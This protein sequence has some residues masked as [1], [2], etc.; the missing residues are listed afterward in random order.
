MDNVI[1]HAKLFSPQAPPENLP[2]P[3][4][5]EH[6]R[7]AYLL[8][9]LVAPAGYGKTRLVAQWEQENQDNIAIRWLK[10]DKADNDP[11]QFLRYFIAA[12]CFADENLS[13]HIDNASGLAH[14]S[15]ALVQYADRPIVIV[16][17]NYHLI[18][19]DDTHA[20]LDFFLKN[21][22]PQLRFIVLSRTKLPFTLADHR[23]QQ[24]LTEIIAQQLS[25]TQDEIASYFETYYSLDL[26]AQQLEIITVKTCGWIACI[27]ILGARLRVAEDIDSILND[28]S[29]R[30]RYLADYFSGQFLDHY[31]SAL[32]SFLIKSS[33]LNPLTSDSC[34]TVLQQKGSQEQFIELE[35][36]GAPIIPLDT[37]QSCY[38]YHP[39]FSEFLNQQLE[40]D[41]DLLVV[42]HER[43]SD[44]YAAQAD[45]SD[46][47]IE[48][49]LFHAGYV[50]QEKILMLLTQFSATILQQGYSHFF[51]TNLKSVP[52][53]ALF[54]YPRLLI[55]YLWALY[56]DGQF[57]KTLA[58]LEQAESILPDSFMGEIYVLR[59]QLSAIENNP[60]KS[61]QLAQQALSML[62]PEDIVFRGLMQFSLARLAFF[63]EGQTNQAITLLTEAISLYEQANHYAVWAI[64]VDCLIAIRQRQGS[65]LEA[66]ALC[67]YSI[68]TCEAINRP[69]FL[70]TFYSQLGKIL[71]ERNFTQ[72]AEKILRYGR[73]LSQKYKGKNSFLAASLTLCRII[74]PQEADTIR[75]ETRA[76]VETDAFQ[77][78]RIAA[79]PN[80]HLAEH[81]WIAPW[82]DWNTHDYN[83]KQDSVSMRSVYTYLDLARRLC[84]GHDPNP[85]KAI[86]L[87]LDLEQFTSKI[88]QRSSLL[89]VL[90]LLALSYK[91]IGDK[92]S[93]NGSLQRA[94]LIAQ[95]TGH[96]RLFLDLGKPMLDLLE[97]IIRT[98]QYT[99]Y[100]LELL[101]NQENPS[102]YPIRAE[103]SK[104]L[105][106]REIDILRLLTDGYSN[107]EIGR[108]FELS[109][110][111][112]R[113]HVKNIYRKLEVNNR[114]RATVRA[115]DLGLI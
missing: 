49:A 100:A 107:P 93:A 102:T 37:S 69:D 57:Y 76:F 74:S 52:Y 115:R 50:H 79:F 95:H 63:Y 35:N 109:V 20:I 2:R 45:V 16:L 108:Y 9:S 87:L 10:L 81:G 89:E 53:E 103:L 24:Q 12:L 58:L 29:G 94:L 82:I 65:L 43:A 23:I 33:L 46:T 47:T 5:I 91:A 68:A 112:I 61:R 15:N 3:R 18:H 34:D 106:P 62:S 84:I 67:R 41:S 113:W 75:Q 36:L 17:D 55:A 42:L 77:I 92:S 101:E 78:A 25:F 8:T 85:R 27:Q 44:W 54:D 66:E 28:F 59:T 32:Q 14:I 88:N 1:L 11:Q 64:A 80:S 40:S 105:T 30:D 86:S 96:R 90:I 73:G 22:I 7:S 13:Q 60:Q 99:D 83:P 39:L 98:G 104:P 56:T 70:G 48:K 4:L 71:Y 97:G 6:L 31:P 111:T 19:H 21:P 72:E 38:Q 26:T 110:S 114:T 51:L